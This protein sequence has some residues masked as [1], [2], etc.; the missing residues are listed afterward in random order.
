[1]LTA[2]ECAQAC[3][4]GRRAAAAD[5]GEFYSAVGQ[6]TMIAGYERVADLWLEPTK[7]EQGTPLDA[8]T[9]DSC[10]Q[11]NQFRDA[12]RCCTACGRPRE[13]AGTDPATRAVRRTRLF[14][15]H[16]ALLEAELRELTAAVAATKP[17]AVQRGACCRMIKAVDAAL[18]WLDTL[19]KPMGS[20]EIDAMCTAQRATLK[21]AC[22]EYAAASPLAQARAAAKR[23]YLQAKGV[24]LYVRKDENADLLFQTEHVEQEALDAQ[25]T[26]ENLFVQKTLSDGATASEAKD[27]LLKAELQVIVGAWFACAGDTTRAVAAQRADLSKQKEDLL[28]QIA[29]MQPLVDEY[30]LAFKRLVRLCRNLSI[31][32]AATRLTVSIWF[33]CSIIPSEL[34]GSY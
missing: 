5:R 16:K 30:R 3:E 11:V 18:D 13:S 22:A 31:P 29:E 4:A 20:A 32:F 21:T 14:E 15:E 9:C 17:I 2:M 1:V 23:A 12:P 25:R 6:L 24:A 34:W 10:G 28:I 7:D 19:G 8:W 27:R 26:A 33:V